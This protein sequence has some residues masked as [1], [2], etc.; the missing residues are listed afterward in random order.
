MKTSKIEFNPNGVIPDNGNYFGMPVEADD[1]ALVLIS[2]PWD[3]TTARRNGSSYAPDAIIEASRKI[4]FYEPSAPYSWRKGIATLPIDY[5]IQDLSHRLRSD[6][7]RVVK[8]YEEM[9]LEGLDNIIYSRRLRH[10]NEGSLAVNDNI[11]LQSQEWLS[12]GKIVGLVGGDQSSAF[13]LMRAVSEKYDG[14]G[15]LHIDSKSDLKEAYQGFE[16]SHAS[17]MHNVL[18][19]LVGV[20]RVVAVGVR[21]FSPAEW[22]RAESD[23]RIKFFTGQYIW[24]SHFEGKIWSKIC[25]EIVAELPARVYV[26]LDIDGLTIECAP[27]NST[28]IPG[29]LRFPEVV[30]LLGRIVAAGKVIV[31]FDLTE[32]VPDMEDKTDAEIA[33]RML[34]KLCSVALKNYD[35]EDVL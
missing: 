15:I 12:R 20:S 5:S 35:A 11:Y 26:S 14:V 16:H 4:D 19:D 6:A 23:E 3:A 18:R 27:H 32:V 24:S 21:E 10:V 34:F 31:G 8:V 17:V 2:A 28:L 29:G 30:Y 7:Q 25:E 1:A 13:G 9:G 33:A 22:E